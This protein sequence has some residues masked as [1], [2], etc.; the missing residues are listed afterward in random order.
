MKIWGDV[1]PR[2]Q[3]MMAWA[4]TL[5]VLTLM[6]A[7][8]LANL[9][10]LQAAN[11]AVAREERLNA[12]L[13]DAEFRMARQENSYRGY[14]LSGEAY[15]VRR[16]E[17]HSE[18]FKTAMA[19][20]RTDTPSAYRSEVDKALQSAEAWRLNVA[21]AGQ[22]LIAEGRLAEAERLVSEIGQSERYLEPVDGAINALKDANGV[23]LE[24]SRR[25]QT[26]AA[27]NAVI[28]LTGGLASVILLALLIGLAASRIVAGS[29]ITM[30]DLMQK[31]RPKS[32]PA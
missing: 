15:Y 19:A 20:A 2:R 7:L 22:R 11:A 18:A 26:Q 23:A 8:V 5:A 9:F 1:P 14:L 24:G 28:A 4:A 10:A 31:I 3:L 16:L 25:A 21:V 6:G 30:V 27:R 12:A 32:T 17:S 13:A 29:T